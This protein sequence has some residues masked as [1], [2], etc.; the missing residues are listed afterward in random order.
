MA[1]FESNLLESLRGKIGHFIFYKVKNQLRI[2]AAPTEYRD[3][4]TPEQQSARR[5]LTACVRFYQRMKET[6]LRE[7]W[8]TA[9]DKTDES[10]GYTYYLKTNMSV[11]LGD[12]NISDFSRLTLCPGSGIPGADRMMVHRDADNSVTLTWDNNSGKHSARNTDRLAIAY[13]RENRA[14]TILFAELPPVCRADER[15][16]FQLP[17]TPGITTHLYCYFVSAEGNTYS[18]D[19]YLKING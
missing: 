19:T 4:N 6:A 16:A 14:F 2:R 12:G 10:S 7:A 9:A 8:K 1:T 3:A 18:P 17:A 15:I 5:R 11:F 13:L